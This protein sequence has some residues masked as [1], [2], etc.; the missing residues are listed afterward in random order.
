MSLLRAAILAASRKDGK[1]GSM[2]MLVVTEFVTLDG[3]MEAPSGE[4]ELNEVLE[5]EAHLLG[6][7]T[8]EPSP[9]PGPSGRA[10]SPTS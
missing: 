1:E 4:P 7:V 9:R 3:V 8:Y 5:A 2:S 6:R 10:S